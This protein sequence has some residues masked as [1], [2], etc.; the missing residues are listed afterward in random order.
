MMS[1]EST[2]S[3]SALM[4]ALADAAA[5]SIVLGS[6]VAAVLAAFR[7][8]NV[9]AKL[10]AWKGL[11]LAALAM[12]ALVLVSPALRV[13]VPLPSFAE[14]GVAV[15]A[16]PATEPD[17]DRTTPVTRILPEESASIAQQP[18]AYPSAEP[19]P[20]TSGIIEQAS[21]PPAPARREIRWTL[22][23]FSIYAAVALALLARILVGIALGN[24]LVRTAT[25]VDEPRALEHLSSAVRAAG[26]R[27][28]PRLAESEMLSVPIMIGVRRPTILLPADGRVW[29]EDELAAVLLHEVSHVARRDALSQRLALIH[30]AIFWFSPLAWWL[31]R[32]LADLSEQAS[33]EAALAGGVDCTRYAEA[34]LGFFAD[35]EAVPARVWWQGVSMAKAGQAEKRVDRILAWRGAMANHMSSRTRTLLVVAFAIVAVPVIALTAAVRLAAYDIQAPPAPAAP[36]APEAAPLAAADPAPAAQAIPAPGPPAVAPADAD[37]GDADVQVMVLPPL[38]RVRVDLPPVDVDLPRVQVN[39]PPVNVNVPPIHVAVPRIHIETHSLPSQD[40]TPG[41]VIFS[42]NG[43]WNFGP[44]WRGAYFIGRYD[45]WGP[46][47]AIVTKDSDALTMSGDRDDA[48]HARSLQKKYSGDFIWFQHDEK[49]YVID[50]AATVNRAKELWQPQVELE[51]QQKDLARQQ[52]DLAKQEEDA[53]NKIQEMK[54]KVPD[55]SADMQK[56]EEAMKKLSAN[57]GTINE[58]SDLQSEIGELQSR[59]GEL[60]SGAG[61]EQGAFGREQ[62]EWGRKMGELGRQQ[63]EL[64]RKQAEESREAARHMQQLLDDAVAKGLAKPE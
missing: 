36:P 54:I 62:G 33:D 4:I 16:G 45:D 48:E 25:R 31:E 19:S 24:R 38:P 8:K 56:L 12:P 23:A 27:S 15:P 46:R 20:M 61:R 47:F 57:G 10:L 14:P 6:V 63:G 58:L 29:E 49:S 55:L 35:L 42:S 60:E 32:H 2:H 50:D 17:V 52:E 39:V 11:L 1:P 37:A 59:I 7:A 13:F 18:R 26:L 21:P 3:A 64:G 34:L 41:A 51:K 43:D 53:A 5:R 44:S 22:I 30:R 40:G 28:L 9:R